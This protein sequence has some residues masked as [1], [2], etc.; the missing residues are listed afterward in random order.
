MKRG[1]GIISLEDL[2]K[3][4][5]KSRTPIVFNY[6]GYDVISFAPPSSGGILIGQ[7]L[8]MIEPF[9][10][11]KMGF[12]TPTSVQLMIEAER[13]SYADRAAHI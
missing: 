13:R 10:V 9:N 3:Y 12:Q 4:K 7:M 5:A 2:K 11:Q 6:R 1:G 8:K